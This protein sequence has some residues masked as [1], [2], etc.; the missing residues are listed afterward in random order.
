M[1]LTVLTTGFLLQPGRW[2]RN[3]WLVPA[4]DP[5]SGRW[6]LREAAKN[7]VGQGMTKDQ[8]WKTLGAPDQ[9][10]ATA[11]AYEYLLSRGPEEYNNVRSFPQRVRHPDTWYLRV[12]FDYEGKV[13]T[14]QIDHDPAY[15]TFE[16]AREGW[17]M[18]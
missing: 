11:G 12:Y 7:H 5:R 16:G 18:K 2:D 8:V 4:T 10:D 14:S 9:V 17:P 15:D 13:L 1:V 3:R 6:E